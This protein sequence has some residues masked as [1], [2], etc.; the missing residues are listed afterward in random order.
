MHDLRVK[1]GPY[2]SKYYLTNVNR[3]TSI[4]NNENYT[5]NRNQSDNYDDKKTL[6]HQPK[7]N[8]K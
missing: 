1:I 3:W 4:D 2:S 6:S 5:N 7:S 8:Q